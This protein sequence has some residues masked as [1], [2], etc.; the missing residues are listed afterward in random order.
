MTVKMYNQDGAE[1]G[2]VELKDEIFGVEPNQALVHQYI[3]NLLA[4]RRQGT[5]STKTRKD[6][7]GGGRK[8]YRQK[9]TGRARAG[10]IRSPLRKGGGTIFGPSP[11]D[12]G[13]TFPK[14]MKRQAIKSVFSDKAKAGS[15]MVVDQF[16]FGEP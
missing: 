11:R 10:T 16:E 8:P 2:S 6:V 5:A 15:I 13:S 14:K 3:V 12:Y 7:R 1:V 4:R 9:G